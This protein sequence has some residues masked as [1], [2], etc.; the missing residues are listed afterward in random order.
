M[1]RIYSVESYPTLIGASADHRVAVKPSQVERF[2]RMAAHEI[3]VPGGEAGP[4]TGADWFSRLV[5]DLKANR[6]ASL[7]IAGEHQ[8]AEVHALAH[9]MNAALGNVG[10]TVQYTPGP[11]DRRPHV[12]AI[13]ALATAM[14]S[15]NVQT[16]LIL[17]GNPAFDAPA[18]V[19]FAGALAKV[20]TSIHVGVYRNETARLCT[21]HV[22]QAHFLESWGDVRS[23]DGTYSVVQPTIAPLHGGR[24]WIEVLARLLG[25]T[26]PK[27]DELVKA[28]FQTVAGDKFSE[29]L[30][31]RTVH[32]GLSFRAEAGE[33]CVSMALDLLTGLR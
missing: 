31:R 29:Q 7:V 30:W 2:A 21:W 28:T 13:T 27:P 15:G 24:T 20:P 10:K 32:D 1:N 22:P 14:Q 17:G 12:E 25:E 4:F 18:D 5:E 3:G 26:L 19:D 6:G 8:P 9:A 33:L 16:L 23:F 11:I